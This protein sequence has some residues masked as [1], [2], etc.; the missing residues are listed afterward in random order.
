MQAVWKSWIRDCT[1]PHLFNVSWIDSTT[2]EVKQ[3]CLSFSQFQSLQIQ[4]LVW[5]RLW[6]FDK[7]VTIYDRSNMCQFEYEG[8]LIK[9]LSLRPKTGQHKQLYFGFAV[10]LPY[11]PLIATL[12]SLLPLVM[13]TLSVNRFLLYCRYYPIIEH[14][15]LHLHLYHTNTCTNYT[16]KL[17]MKI[18]RATEAYFAN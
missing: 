6:L 2:L 15:S 14:S 13:Y 1:L 7:Y 12:P 4:D 10:D 8:K 9:L 18:N 17:V 16:K 5:C 3:W 11:P